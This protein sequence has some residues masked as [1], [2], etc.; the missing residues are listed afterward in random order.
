MARSAHDILRRKGLEIGE[1][2][3]DFMG[4]MRHKGGNIDARQQGNDDCRGAV[5]QRT[6]ASSMV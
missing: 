2:D 1:R 3:L 4:P 6:P 5:W